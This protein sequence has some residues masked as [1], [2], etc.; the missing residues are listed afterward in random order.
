MNCSIKLK[1]AKRP[2]AHSL[3]RF[4]VLITL[5][6]VLVAAGSVCALTWSSSG[7]MG[8]GRVGHTATL[9]PNGNVLVVGGL[10]ANGSAE[11]YDPAAGT[12]TAT[13]N[14]VSSRC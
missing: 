1:I 10:G 8:K 9:L 2:A 13:G 3:S 5:V 11:L 7:N 12:W 14:P 4:P 6:I